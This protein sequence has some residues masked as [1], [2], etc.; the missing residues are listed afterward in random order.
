MSTS[1]GKGMMNLI[2]GVDISRWDF[3]R[4][5]KGMEGENYV[6]ERLRREDFQLVRNIY[7]T[8]EELGRPTEIDILAVSR[9]GVF[10]IEVK[11]VSGIV[12]GNFRSQ[13]W[14]LSSATGTQMSILN[15]IVQNEIH[16]GALEESL[17]GYSYKNIVIYGRALFNLNLEDDPSQLYVFKVDRFIQAVAQSKDCLTREEVAK[18]CMHFN[19]FSDKTL[20]RKMKHKEDLSSGLGYSAYEYFL[21]RHND[22]LSRC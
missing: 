3:E 13:Y 19:K 5:A 22:E 8:N 17:K 14:N 15:P 9:K 7:L 20:E 2:N 4:F 6:A 11:N 10:C 12:K 21:R 16:V 18:I 1:Y